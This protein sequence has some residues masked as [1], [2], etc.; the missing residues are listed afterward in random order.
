MKFVTVLAE[1][2]PR[3]PIEHMINPFLV[4]TPRCEPFFEEDVDLTS[5]FVTIPSTRATKE[6]TILIIWSCDDTKYPENPYIREKFRLPWHGEIMVCGTAVHDANRVINLRPR[7]DDHDVET[8]IG[9][10]LYCFHVAFLMF[11]NRYVSATRIGIRII[12]C[13]VGWKISIEV[14]FTRIVQK[15]LNTVALSHF[16]AL[17]SFGFYLRFELRR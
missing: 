15:K 14:Y 7:K 11:S 5:T 4:W 1:H 12:E 6:R 2:T 13:D 9:S 16:L 17:C 3:V 8:A 10:F